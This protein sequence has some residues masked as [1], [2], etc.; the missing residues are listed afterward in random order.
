MAKAPFD[1]DKF[2]WVQLKADLDGPHKQHNET[3]TEKLGRKFKE[4]PL[5]PI[6]KLFSFY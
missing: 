2:D 6:G 3:F 5:V 1:P 4:N